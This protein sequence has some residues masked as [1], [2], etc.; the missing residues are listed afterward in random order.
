MNESK[1]HIHGLPMWHDSDLERKRLLY[2]GT[3]GD[4]YVV[5][6]VPSKQ[7][8]VQKLYYSWK[9]LNHMECEAKCFSLFPPHKNIVRAVACCVHDGK[10]DGGKREAYASIIL[11]YV[12]GPDLFD[13]LVVAD[14]S[15]E[16]GQSVVDKQF[17]V[18]WSLLQ[19]ELIECKAKRHDT[20]VRYLRG[21]CEALA[22]LHRHGIVHGDIKPENIVVGTD[23]CVRLI[24]L[25]MASFNGHPINDQKTGLGTPEFMPPEHI[26]AFLTNDKPC[27]TSG[28]DMWSFGILAAELLLGTTFFHDSRG[29]QNSSP[30]AMEQAWMR[31]NESAAVR[32]HLAEKMKCQNDIDPHLS[33]MCLGLLRYKAN[34]RLSAK[35]CLQHDFFAAKAPENKET[36]TIQ[37]Y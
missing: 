9:R 1:E 17:P 22:H 23:G 27:A 24:D 20:A 25:D 11:E 37:C 32:A 4:L 2:K 8:Y 12:D 7:L 10:K 6:H 29:H 14:T 34:Q 18:Q 33:S 36:L 19:Q 3:F 5:V 31:M 16:A 35:A 21:V 15:S 30:H 28:A 13:F 26:H